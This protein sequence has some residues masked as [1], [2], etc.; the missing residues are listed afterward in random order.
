LRLVPPR[1]EGVRRL[2]LHGG[3]GMLLLVVAGT[4]D[5]PVAPAVERQAVV[6]GAL[7][8]GYPAVGAIVPVV[9]TCGEPLPVYASPRRGTSSWD[10]AR[11]ARRHVVSCEHARVP[12]AAQ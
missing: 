11:R 1:R 2:R 5:A 6:G 12:A 10:V 9:P 4:C 3:A 7:E 8:P